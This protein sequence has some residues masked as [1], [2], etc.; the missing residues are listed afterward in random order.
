[1]ENKEILIRL[2]RVLE[3][4]QK[5]LVIAMVAMVAVAGFSGAQAYMV[6]PL[7]DEIFVNKDPLLLNLLP[8]ALLAVFFVKGIFYFVYSYLLE[9]VGQCVIRDLRNRLF[10]HLNNLSLSFY[11]RTPTGELISRIINDVTLLQDAVSYALVRILRDFF[12]VIVLLVVIFVMNWQLALISLVFIPMAAIPIVVFGKKFRKV[13]T[14]YQESLGEATSIL[15]EAIGGVRIV[16]A[17]CMEKREEKRFSARLD[18]IFESLMK[19]TKYNCLSHPMLEL[20]AGV[21]IALIIWFG[22]MQV[23]RGES[24]PGTFMAFL[25]AMMMLY[26]PVKGISKINATIQVG[27]AAAIRIF[28]LLDVKSDIVEKK[29]AVVIPQFHDCLEFVGLNFSY[30][31]DEPVLKNINLTIRCGEVLAVVGASGGGKTTLANLFPRFYD[32][33]SGSLLIDGHDVRDVTLNSLRNQIALVTQQTILFNDTVANNISY[34]SP[35]SNNE[36]IIKAA[37]AAFALE[38]IRELPNGFDTVIGESGER[39]SGG[40][41]QRISIARAILK[42]APILILDE[43]TSA[44]DTESE[45]KVQQAL[46]N[47]MKDRTTIVIAHRLSTIINAD[48]IIVMGKGMLVEEGSHEE[49]LQLGGVYASLHGMQSGEVLS[50]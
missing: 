50:F 35:D 25:V 39:L 45:K 36:E 21:G 22:G 34:G 24:T 6:K 5:K 7:L 18:N 42:N 12:S 48:R 26:E 27:L 19:E 28:T 8:L 23:L 16:K 17:F 20:M 32:V 14:D 29:D 33:D 13:S 43:A 3:P 41:R 46:E 38:F 31:P 37:T 30:Q 1:M 40:Q 44:L 4:Y 47:L 15:H 9:W 2:Y 49:L 11:H 10:S